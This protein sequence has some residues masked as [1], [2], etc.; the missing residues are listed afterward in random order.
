MSSAATIV[1]GW[2]VGAGWPQNI[3]LNFKFSKRGAAAER[4]KLAA[5]VEAG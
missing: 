5:I 1:T 4:Y 2:G 3:I